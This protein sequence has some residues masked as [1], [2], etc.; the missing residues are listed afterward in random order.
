M[1]ARRCA[2]EALNTWEETSVYADEILADLS[3]QHRLSSPDRGLT[4]EI[5]YGTIRNLFLVDE[6]IDRLRR[7]RIKSST[8]NI[9]R[10]GLF[11]IFK[12]GIANHAA[13]NETVNLARSHEK[14]LVNAILR[15]ALRREDEFRA[16]IE[17]WPWEDRYSHSAFLIEKWQK[18]YGDEATLA[19]L[20]WNNKPPRVFG[21][22]NSL[23]TNQEAL[24]RVRSEIESS[25]LGNEYP[26]FFQL[27]GAP[28]PE[29]LKE[30]LIY[31]QDP[32]TSRAC[33]LLDPKPGESILDA[34]AAPGGKT[35]LLAA[36]MQNEGSILA[37]DSSRRRLSQTEENLE[38]LGVGNAK[39]LQHDWLNS[40][41]Q[42]F[43]SFDA[44]LLDVPC[45]NT[46]VMRRRV[47]VRWRLQPDEFAR[48][49]EIQANLL[50]NV[51]PFLK[52]EG[53]IIYSTCSLDSAENE[54]VIE[55]SGLT[56]ESID[57]SLPWQNNHDG[58]FAAVLR[59]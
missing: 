55:S 48:Q 8:Q 36:M 46:G 10:I 42:D 18:Q 31:I 59:P 17:T 29:W 52:P 47:D 32:S 53:R 50:K 6:L 11:Q 43:E 26:D 34:C 27:D 15:N 9:L 3:N 28:D 58:A 41:R 12:S 39:L 57:R 24:N 14:G 20:E 56:I 44:I 33:R 25:L 19:L 16:Q 54:A 2:L 22:L 13:V 51:S 38:R 30:G 21:R 23:A 45:S 37:T 4:Q 7:G 1:S 40:G 49:A 5:F 35:A